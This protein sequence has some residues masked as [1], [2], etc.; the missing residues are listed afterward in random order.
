MRVLA[1]EETQ[2]VEN[3]EDLE[4]KEDKEES[5]QEADAEEHVVAVAGWFAAGTLANLQVAS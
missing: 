3:L 1:E 4:G 2:K 5:E